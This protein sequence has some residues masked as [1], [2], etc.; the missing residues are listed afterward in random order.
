MGSLTFFLYHSNVHHLTVQFMLVLFTQDLSNLEP[1][2]LTTEVFGF[3]LQTDNSLCLCH[4]YNY[5]AYYNHPCFQFVSTSNDQY[6][7]DKSV[8]FSL[9]KNNM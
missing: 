6:G 2:L 1:T 8:K 3:F 9:A 5:F 7:L 4:H